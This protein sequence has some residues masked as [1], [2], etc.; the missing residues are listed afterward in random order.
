MDRSAKA[1]GP[2][3]GR[4]SD[5]RG[6]RDGGHTRC[7]KIPSRQSNVGTKGNRSAKADGNQNTKN[8][9]AENLNIWYTNADSLPNK[10]EELKTRIS[11]SKNK[12]NII[13]V[14][15]AKP[16]NQRYNLMI[17]EISIAGY[18]ISQINVDKKQGRGIIIYTETQISVN[19]ITPKIIADEYL[20]I[21]LKL[22]N[23]TKMLISAIY[24]SPNSSEE[25][26]KKIL[27]LI[28]EIDDSKYDHKI[29]VGDFNLPKI[30]WNSDGGETGYEKEF[31]D[32]T[33]N[34]YLHQHIQNPTRAR[35]TN[36]PSLI[37]LVLTNDPEC[38]KEVRYESPLGKSD[39][40]VLVLDTN[41]ITKADEKRK[42]KRYIYIRGDYE[43]MK[44]ELNKEWEETF[45]GMNTQDKWD[46][47]SELLN[48]CMKKHIP[49]GGNNNKSNKNKFLDPKLLTKIKKKNRMWHRYVETKE[50]RKYK[51]FTKLR[52]QVRNETRKNKII[53]EK[54]VAEEAKTNPKLFWAYVS[55]KT[56]SRS[57][58]S[59]LEYTED[60]KKKLTQNDKEKSE[61]LSDFFTSVFTDEPPGDIP[62]LDTPKAKSEI[63]SIKITVEIV[64]KKLKNLNP[65]KSPG[66]DELHPKLLKETTQQIKT[67][68]YEIF[69]TSLEEGKI[70]KQWKLGNISA[71]Y[72][73]GKK[74]QPGNYRPVSLTSV[75]CKLLESIVRDQIMKYMTDNNL[76]SN[77]QYGFISGRSTTLQLLVVLEEW[78]EI[79]DRGGTVGAVYMDFMKAFD[80]VPHKRLIKKLEHYGI[81]GRVV[82]WIEDF[83]NDRSQR[84]NVGEAHSEWRPVTSGIP[85]GSVLGPLLFAIYINDLPNDLE[86]NVY[87]FAD[88]TKIYNEIGDNGDVERMQRDLDR[89]DRWSQKWLLKFHPD[90]CKILT[91]CNQ[92]GGS[93][94]LHLYDERKCRVPLAQCEE[95]KDIG[96][97][98][99][100]KLRFSKHLNEKVTKA[101]QIMGLIRRTFDYMDEKIFTQLFKTLVRPI[102]EYAN[103]VWAPYRLE[104]IRSV[105]S[106]QRQATKKIKGMKDMSYEERLRKLG[107]PTLY[108][109]RLRGDM[110][111]TFKI[112][113]GIYDREACPKLVRDPNTK[114]TRGH[115]YKLAKIRANTDMRK[116]FFTI[117]VMEAW[118]G[119]PAEV[120]EAETTNAFKNGLDRVWTNH[121]DRFTPK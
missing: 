35:G 6:L 96:V 41:L 19:E 29:I 85:Q 65:N 77:K 9:K 93:I 60:G 73:K 14:T 18:N 69:K 46:R 118:N 55:N 7:N 25:N 81:K 36:Q 82:R 11:A 12:P 24:R 61:V 4:T 56:K 37:D 108:F 74:N 26:N 75:P 62:E 57:G 94:N 16:K 115:P 64:E 51:E 76:F 112:M 27:E 70:P 5:S 109:R 8:I 13:I 32:C 102:V 84:V 28:N 45:K 71:I 78:T 10:M 103:S 105:E 68:L 83:L 30:D 121:P 89:L 48:D 113:R 33:K 79:M 91:A 87:M 38:L 90:K 31:K 80:T 88:D 54:K 3:K 40:A 106:V 15:E 86:T 99:D 34:C 116:N 20:G 59:D 17:P 92:T 23:N 52:N 39:H 22:K 47:F 2:Y 42:P 43:S 97:T 111:E 72:K 53:N 117:R 107:L 66:L 104:D 21:D 101:N 58:I 110:I 119:L 67:P 114:G 44:E 1:D 98:I 100:N 95:E 63:N 50:F 49:K 120:V